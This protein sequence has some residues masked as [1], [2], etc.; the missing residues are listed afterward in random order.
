[1]GTYGVTH[2]KKDEKIIP[3]SDSYDGYFDAMGLANI[4]AIKHMD[5]ALL[6]RLADSYTAHLEE[7]D[8]I[9]PDSRQIEQAIYEF[10][11]INPEPSAVEWFN[12]ALSQE[13]RT[14]VTGVGPLLFLNITPHYGRDFDYYDYLL[15]LNTRTYTIQNYT[16][17]FDTLRALSEEKIRFLGEYEQNLI[18]VKDKLGFDALVSEL[19]DETSEKQKKI[20]DAFLEKLIKLDNKKV[21]NYFAKKD[22]QAQQLRDTYMAEHTNHSSISE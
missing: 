13:I 3:L 7:N 17:S 16:V 19:E 10:S 9:V 11:Q 21:V 22:L 18:Q 2:V 12:G 1:M 4:W 8:G 14:S 6:A 5:D 20:I 15:D